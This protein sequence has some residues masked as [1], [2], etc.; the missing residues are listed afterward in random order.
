MSWATATA[1]GPPALGRPE[2]EPGAQQHPGAREYEHRKL[3]AGPQQASSNSKTHLVETRAARKPTTRVLTL[4]RRKNEL[5]ISPNRRRGDS[6]LLHYR[7]GSQRKNGP[8]RPVD[9]HEQ[10]QHDQHGPSQQ[11]PVAGLLGGVV[12]YRMLDRGSFHGHSATRFLSDSAVGDR[13]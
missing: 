11:G 1:I 7:L 10:H 8:I 5:L 4:N 12:Y 2:H 13:R 3:S 9:D 6:E